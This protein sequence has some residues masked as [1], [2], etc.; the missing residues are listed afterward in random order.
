M[1]VARL[2][3]SLLE[4]ACVVEGWSTLHT[5]KSQALIE[6]SSSMIETLVRD[7]KPFC[8]IGEK[9]RAIWTEKSC[10]HIIQLSRVFVDIVPSSNCFQG[11]A[12]WC[13]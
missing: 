4:L 12:E 11:D 6:A 2:F 8:L 1:S 13:F 10:I 7:C 5:N 9:L 3:V